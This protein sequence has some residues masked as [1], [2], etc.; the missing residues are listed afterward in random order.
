MGQGYRR[1]DGESGGE[2]GLRSGDG[3]YQDAEGRLWIEGGVDDEIVTGGENVVASTVAE[4]IRDHPSVDDAAVVGLPDE[5]WGQRVAA[6]VVGDVS[7][8]TVREHCSEHLAAYEVPKTVRIADA[9]PRTASG[10]VDR[11]AVRSL[12]SE[13]GE[14]GNS[15][16]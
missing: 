7:P 1:G 14:P 16:R 15:S 6:L 11:E 3:N 2:Y 5:E 12:L 9:L 8:E 4:T 10:T 13:A